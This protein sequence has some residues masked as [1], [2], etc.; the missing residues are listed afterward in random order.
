MEIY[1][2]ALKKKTKENMSLIPYNGM[3]RTYIYAVVKL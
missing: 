1:A 2:N 3:Y